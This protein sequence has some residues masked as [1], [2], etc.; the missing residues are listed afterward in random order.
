MNLCLLSPRV[1]RLNS[2]WLWQIGQCA[3]RAIQMDLC[4][5][6]VDVKRMFEI[7]DKGDF[8]R[9]EFAARGVL[10]SSATSIALEQRIKPIQKLAVSDCMRLI[11]QF[12]QRMDIAMMSQMQGRQK[13][14]LLSNTS[15]PKSNLWS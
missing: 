11:V 1:D 9:C 5:R 2:L 13:F 6:Q 14:G 4:R 15:R 8:H 12:S 10:R 7:G 3:H